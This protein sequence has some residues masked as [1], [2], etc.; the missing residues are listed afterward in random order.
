MEFSLD[1]L[2]NSLE[3]ASDILQDSVLNFDRDLLNQIEMSNNEIP[4]DVINELVNAKDTSSDEHH[5]DASDDVFQTSEE[6]LPQ[7]RAR[8]NTWPKLPLVQ[9]LVGQRVKYNI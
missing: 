9:G 2:D 5:L 8:S 7:S 6:M 4:M 1:L 3:I